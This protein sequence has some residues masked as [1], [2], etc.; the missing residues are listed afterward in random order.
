MSTVRASTHDRLPH[1]HGL[2]PRLRPQP[3]E[4]GSLVWN[5]GPFPRDRLRCL[6]YFPL[7]IGKAMTRNV[8]QSEQA[9][10]LTPDIYAF[11]TTC[12]RC[13]KVH[14]HNYVVLLARV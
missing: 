7:G 4:D 10:A 13:A 9:R 12:P 14:G 6:R 3:W 11:Y 5:E 1:S 2:L 8:G